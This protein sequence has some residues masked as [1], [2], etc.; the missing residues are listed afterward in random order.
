MHIINDKKEESGGGKKGEEKGRHMWLGMCTDWI[1]GT[2]TVYDEKSDLC[3]QPVTGVMHKITD[4]GIG[5]GHGRGGGDDGT[6][7]MS[8]GGWGDGRTGYS[9]VETILNLLLNSNA[10]LPLIPKEDWRSVY[11]ERYPWYMSLI[12]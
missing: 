11:G 5:K 10:M 3:Q 9:P 2:C 8:C 1:D 4:R 6:R 12:Q 7:G